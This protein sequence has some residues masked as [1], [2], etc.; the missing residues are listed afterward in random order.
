MNDNVLTY[1]GYSARVLFSAEDRLLYGKIEGIADLV[2]FQSDSAEEVE[3]VFHEAVDDYLA[4]CQDIGKVPDK[5]YR[6][7]FN[8]RVQPS[9]HRDLDRAAAR[10][11]ISM[12]QFVERALM[13]AVEA[14]K[15]RAPYQKADASG[16]LEGESVRR[17][18][19]EAPVREGNIV[20]FPVQTC[21]V[22]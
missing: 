14:D 20:Q 4:F 17:I 1:K 21:A 16:N 18:W 12:N 2:N 13:S 11:G 19:N 3:T 7:S 9:L 6:G 22:N 8:V 10:H 15:V 5:E